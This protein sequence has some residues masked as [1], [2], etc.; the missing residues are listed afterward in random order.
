MRIKRRQFVKIASGA[1]VGWLQNGAGEASDAA[2]LP[3]IDC[4]THF[5]DP[6]R[7]GGIPWPAASDR[8]LYRRVLPEHF[9]EQATPV[10]VTQTV[11]VEASPRVE[12]NAWLLEL[13]QKDRS[14]VGVV[15]HLTP[16]IPEFR[17]HLG[18]FARNPLF[19]G[20]RISHETLKKGLDIPDF[21]ADIRRL[22][23]HDLELD[24]NGGPETPFDVAH[25]A[26]QI[27]DLRIVIN[28]LANLDLDGQAPPAKWVEA[29]RSAARHP[30]VFCKVS[31]LVEHA[32]PPGVKPP[33]PAPVEAEFYRP[34]LDSIWEIFGDDRLIYGSNWPVSD[35][36]ASYKSLFSIVDLYVRSRGDTAREKFFCRNAQVAYQF[37]VRR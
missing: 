4:H 24:V 35:L 28:H 5:Y 16:G 18:R 37:P 21:L 36:A 10:G 19:R 11:V 17:E 32:R 26:R 27:P 13:A 8:I 1:A 29:M 30:R 3:L 20:L 15:G 7:P 33:A 9:L 23:E 14:I 34:V 25:L 6:T 22:A 12:D 31:A 2:P